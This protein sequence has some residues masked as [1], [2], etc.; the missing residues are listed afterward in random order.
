MCAYTFTFGIHNESVLYQTSK[1]VLEALEVTWSGS[2]PASS[3]DVCACCKSRE[4]RRAGCCEKVCA[5]AGRASVCL[6]VHVHVHVCYAFK[7][8]QWE[9]RPSRGCLTSLPIRHCPPPVSYQPVA[10]C[11][12][13]IRLED[14]YMCV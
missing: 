9:K 12:S 10:K 2:G 8:L 4:T 1:F 11:S 14:R 3:I 6:Y 13:D 7:T 5:G